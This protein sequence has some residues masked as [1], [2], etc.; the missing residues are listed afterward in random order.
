[1]RSTAE[2]LAEWTR[3]VLKG[4]GRDERCYALFPSLALLS[5]GFSG[6]MPGVVDERSWV[7]ILELVHKSEQ[8]WGL[9]LCSVVKD[10][11]TVVT[12]GGAADSDRGT[13]RDR[14]APMRV[15]EADADFTDPAPVAVDRSIRIDVAIRLGRPPRQVRCE[16]EAAAGWG[17][18]SALLWRMMS[19]SRAADS[20]TFLFFFSLNCLS[21]WSFG[22][23]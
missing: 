5:G 13:K 7:A 6:S 9:C 22:R 3:R 12:D 14:L 11:G 16:N 21:C 20:F 23:R 4:E 2:V 17:L 15:V 10:A 19:V 1:M 8:L 18:R